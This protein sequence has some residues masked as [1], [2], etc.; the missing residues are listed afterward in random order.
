MKKP[1]NGGIAD[2]LFSQLTGIADITDD[3][4]NSISIYPNPVQDVL[5]INGVNENTRINVFNTS[6]VLLQTA[7]AKE[8][9]VEL[10]VSTL[11]QDVYILQ[12]GNQA[13]KFIKSK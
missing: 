12:A 3:A 6:G 13:I 4:G 2:F 5:F 1:S 10:N 9:T 11:P 7:I 8:K